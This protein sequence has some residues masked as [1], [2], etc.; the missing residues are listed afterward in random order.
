MRFLRGAA[1]VVLLCCSCGGA[2]ESLAGLRSD[3][4][5]TTRPAG[6]LAISHTEAPARVVEGRHRPALVEE[7][8]SVGSSSI[9]LV[10]QFYKGSLSALGWTPF[11]LPAGLD[12]RASYGW[13]KGNRVFALSIPDQPPGTYR[14]SEG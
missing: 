9:S 13:K 4:A 14:I 8:D 6:V 7:T 10:V 2:E 11:S 5:F 3:P 12:E 1:L